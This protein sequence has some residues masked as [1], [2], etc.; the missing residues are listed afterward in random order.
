MQAKAEQEAEGKAAAKAA[1]GNQG[2]AA[3]RGWGHCSVIIWVGFAARAGL[4]QRA[5]IGG[6]G[7]WFGGGSVKL[8]QAG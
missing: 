3:G 1:E 8:G 7:C 2:G 4:S 6:H 5:G